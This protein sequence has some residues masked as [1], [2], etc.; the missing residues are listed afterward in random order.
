[1]D[2]NILEEKLKEDIIIEGINEKEITKEYIE[3][4]GTEKFKVICIEELG[5]LIQEITKSLRQESNN[6]TIGLK[7]EFVDV[8]IILNG[9]KQ[10]FNL[11]D[12]ELSKISCIKSKRM[13][14]RL[15]EDNVI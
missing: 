11:D 4:I 9:L 3:R 5:E 1:M 7:E 13:Q 12:F 8:S 10:I 6:P 14:K 15:K 2:R